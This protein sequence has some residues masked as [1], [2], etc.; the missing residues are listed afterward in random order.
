MKCK[1]KRCGHEWQTRA[2]GMPQ[3]CPACKTY[4]W[5]EPKRKGAK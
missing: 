1:C 2:P 4:R 3:A 5:M